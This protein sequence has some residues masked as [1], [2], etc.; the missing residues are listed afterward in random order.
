MKL[1]HIVPTALL[2]HTYH[3]DA[4]LCLSNLIARDEFYAEFH[5]QQVAAGKLVI[6]DNPVHENEPLNLDEWSMAIQLLHP[7]VINL[8]DVIDDWEQTVALAKVCSPRA[9]ALSPDSY[10]MAV[11]HG[12][13]HSDFLA[14]VRQLYALRDP[15]IDWF[16][17]SLERRLENDQL[18]FERRIRRIRIL[19]TEP[20]INQRNVHLLGVSE[21]AYE[22]RSPIF[23]HVT[24]ADTSKFAVWALNGDPLFPPAPVTVPYPGRESLG[25][26]VKYFGY[27]PPAGFDPKVLFESLEAWSH[28]AENGA[29]QL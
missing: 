6:L 7:T 4:F 27:D 1:A 10:L 16:G 22:L 26:S 5:R 20:G 19:Q 25:G 15:V 9:H 17:V 23:R 3:Q 12:V 13:E 8:P 28:Y 29:Y 21:Q 2:P 18:A 11:P 14:C 24:S